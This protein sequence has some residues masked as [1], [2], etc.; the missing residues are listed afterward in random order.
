ME[1]EGRGQHPKKGGG[2]EIL[3]LYHVLTRNAGC[4]VEG[5]R[6]KGGGGRGVVSG[7]QRDMLMPLLGG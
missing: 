5:E 2:T 7:A 6:V 4:F 1:E 3:L